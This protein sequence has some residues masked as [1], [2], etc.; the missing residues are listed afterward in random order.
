M[1]RLL[2]LPKSTLFFYFLL[3]FISVEAFNKIFFFN[4]DQDFIVQ[5]V[6][7]LIAL[8]LMLG[9]LLYQSPRK[10]IIPALLIGFFLLGQVFL[11]DS[12]VFSSVIGFSRYLFFI[13]MILFFADFQQLSF[14]KTQLIFK[15]WEIFLWINNILIFL[16]VA[17]NLFIFKAYINERWGYNGLITASSN[18]TYLYLV[19]LL[20]FF[21]RFPKTYFKKPL[22]WLSIIAAFCTGT[23][24]IYLGVL[25]FGFIA[26]VSFPLPKKWKWPLILG[27]FLIGM[28]SMLLLF[29]S[30][31]F[32]G[33]IQEDGWL[34]AILSYRDELLIEDTLPYIQE[35]WRT[36]HYFVGGL[37]QPLA[38]PQLELIDLFLYFGALGM[39]PYLYLFFKNYF[40]FSLQIREIAFY[41][42]LLTVPLITGNFFYN[43]SVPIYLIL[44][45]LVIK[46]RE[47]TSRT[48]RSNQKLKPV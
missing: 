37:S 2:N 36:I 28:A 11:P 34:S 18:S 26:L 12:F 35:N 7:K 45:K 29:S 39:L 1:K 42:V 43:A 41:V 4:T 44:L 40:N 16:A 15:F 23:K 19:A 30:E 21:I 24:S 10:L 3:I 31:L 20:Y 9:M 17:F 38:R 22:F 6:V 47:F 14:N 27:L 5:K 48:A 46:E 8:A 25:L 33:I 13:I 32:T